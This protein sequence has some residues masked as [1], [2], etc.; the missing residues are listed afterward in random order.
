MLSIFQQIVSDVHYIH[1]RGLIHRDLN[2][3]YPFTKLIDRLNE[4]I[5][6]KSQK[7]FSLDGNIKI[8]DFG[9]VTAAAV[10]ED[11][12]SSMPNEA[13]NTTNPVILNQSSGPQTYNIGTELYESWTGIWYYFL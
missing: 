1:S 12:R 11:I 6:I 9:L 10:D 3:I 13:E 2:V 8:G 7:I 5:F 4:I